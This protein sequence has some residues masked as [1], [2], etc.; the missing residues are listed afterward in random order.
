MA[1]ASA[2]LRSSTLSTRSINDP[3]ASNRA[4]S[5]PGRSPEER[6]GV[7]HD[8]SR[9]TARFARVVSVISPRSL[10]RTTSCDLPPGNRTHGYAA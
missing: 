5:I 8:P 6:G 3:D 9:S 2:T 4:R 1:T 10:M 7:H